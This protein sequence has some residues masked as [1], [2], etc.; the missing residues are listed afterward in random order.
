MAKAKG[1]AQARRLAIRAG[2]EAK[3]MMSMVGRPVVMVAIVQACQAIN[4]ASAWQADGCVIQLGGLGSVPQRPAT[5]A[6]CRVVACGGE[7]GAQDG[8]L[9]GSILR[10]AQ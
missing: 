4:G 1:M 2:G 5:W 8:V 10:G 9:V 7:R 3:G 6:G